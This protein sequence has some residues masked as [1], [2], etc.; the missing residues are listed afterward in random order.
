MAEAA[1]S[2]EDKVRALKSSTLFS[3]LHERDISRIARLSITKRY[4]KGERIF[5]EGEAA[6][7]FYI[8]AHGKVKIAKMS[9]EGKEHILGMF[10]K[11]APFGEAAMF[12]GRKYPAYA[13]AAG[14]VVCLY[15]QRRNLVGEIKSNPELAF[16]MLATL[17][18]RLGKFARAIE[19]LSLKEVSA[20]LAKY[21]L[22]LSAKQN[23]PSTIHLDVK[24]GE[25]ASRL[26]AVC[27]TLSRT[28]ARLKLQKVIAVE[29]GEV[30][31]LDREKLKKISAGYKL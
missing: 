22:D 29:G 11:G 4:T 30:K 8:V 24:K 27:E 25:L 5:S 6:D 21:I 15:I 9:V 7:G 10:S 26:G 16:G 17:S 19:D 31:L 20:R 13:S 23:N 1:L 3:S 28:L 2:F 18:E 12:A 14:N